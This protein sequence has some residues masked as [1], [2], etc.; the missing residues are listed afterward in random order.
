MNSKLYK[1]DDEM[2]IY[3]G[4]CFMFLGLNKWIHAYL[5]LLVILY[6]MVFWFAVKILQLVVF[7]FTVLLSVFVYVIS[8]C[9]GN[10]LKGRVVPIFARKG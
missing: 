7:L 1:N 8:F 2:I 9:F 4:G 5:G 3:A 10:L 6:G